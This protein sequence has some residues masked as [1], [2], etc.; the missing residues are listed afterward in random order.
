[1]L[2]TG[3]GVHI[4]TFSTGL[5]DSGDANVVINRKPEIADSED[6]GVGFKKQKPVD[7]P[8]DPMKAKS[9][10]KKKDKD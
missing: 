1:M 4:K 5:S 9:V 10:K 7:D 3:P 8:M 2:Y 6:S